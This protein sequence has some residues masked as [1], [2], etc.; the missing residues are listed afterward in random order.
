MSRLIEVQRVEDCRSPLKVRVGD[1][2]VLP[3]TGARVAA[4][5]P[6]VELSGPFRSAVIGINGEVM[7][8]AGAPNT[9]LARARHPGSATIE[10]FTSVPFHASRPTALTVVVE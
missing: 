8:P 10:V 2:L 4:G 1:V 9:I 7:A 6:A 5:R 3:A